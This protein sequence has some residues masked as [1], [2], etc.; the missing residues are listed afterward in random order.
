MR[1]AIDSG[2]TFTDCVFVEDGQLKVLKIF[3]TP[4]DPGQAVLASILQIADL[5]EAP[6]VRHGTTVGT[7]AI[8]ERK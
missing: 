2:G 4:H 6:E 3:S 8:L 1:L 7:N 5:T